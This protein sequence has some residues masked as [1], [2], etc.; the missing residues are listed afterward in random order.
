[1]LDN[2]KKE[3]FVIEDDGYVLDRIRILLADVHSGVKNK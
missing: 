1:L 3:I 2:K